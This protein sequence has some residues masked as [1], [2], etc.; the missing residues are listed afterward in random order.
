MKTDTVNDDASSKVIINSNSAITPINNASANT[1]ENKPVTIINRMAT[2]DNHTEY[3]ENSNSIPSNNNTLRKL[4]IIIT[5]QSD[6][7]LNHEKIKLTTVQYDDD[8]DSL[9]SS[10]IHEEPIMV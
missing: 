1:E 9:T 8:D 7:G 4:P 10:S 3:S 5:S 2:F 6:D